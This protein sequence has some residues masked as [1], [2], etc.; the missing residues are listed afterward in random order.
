M[1]KKLNLIDLNN[2]DA[3]LGEMRRI[4]GGSADSINPI[5][6]CEKYCSCVENPNSQTT[7]EVLNASPDTSKW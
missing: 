7:S 3:K 2:Y 4:R 5:D 6:T 1:L